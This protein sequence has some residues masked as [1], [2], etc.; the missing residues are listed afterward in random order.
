MSTPPLLSPSQNP[1]AS[2]NQSEI[3]A[4]GGADALDIGIERACPSDQAAPKL[5][6]F[7]AKISTLVQSSLKIGENTVPWASRYLSQNQRRLE[8]G[9]I[10]RIA[11]PGRS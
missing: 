11:G 1:E 2:P 8:S 9:R 3:V 4:K 5:G 7:S 6:A 10:A